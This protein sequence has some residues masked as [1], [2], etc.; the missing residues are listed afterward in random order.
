MAGVNRA[1]ML[2]TLMTP[3]SAPAASSMAVAL[4][5]TP[6]AERVAPGTP[7]TPVTSALI[8]PELTMTLE[9]GATPGSNTIAVTLA[10]GLALA[11]SVFEPTTLT[12]PLITMRGTLAPAPISIP[13]AAPSPDAS[14]MLA[15]VTV[16]LTSSPPSRVTDEKLPP[17]ATPPES[18]NSGLT[19]PIWMAVAETF[20]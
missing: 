16:P 20:G 6:P 2:P 5:V 10:G 12:D 15:A 7:A 18:T 17:G 4:P 1:V 19:P 3:T 8:R 13:V 14:E 11:P 9:A